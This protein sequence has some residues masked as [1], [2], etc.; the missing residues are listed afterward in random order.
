MACP[1]VPLE[2]KVRHIMFKVMTIRKA[3]EMGYEQC[4]G[5]SPELQ[6]FSAVVNTVSGHCPYMGSSKNAVELARRLNASA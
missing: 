4:K 5:F 1:F 3:A 6:D 2:Q